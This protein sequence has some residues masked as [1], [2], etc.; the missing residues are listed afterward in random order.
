[1]KK[2]K[3]WTF[4]LLYY[5]YAT[6]FFI[7]LS[8]IFM[9]STGFFGIPLIS[10]FFADKNIDLIQILFAI[11]SLLVCIWGFMAYNQFDRITKLVKRTWS[12]C[13][14]LDPVVGEYDYKTFNPETRQWE[15]G[16][17]HYG[18][19]DFWDRDNEV[20]P[21]MDKGKYWKILIELQK[22]NK[23]VILQ[24]TKD[25]N[26]PFNQGKNNLAI[27]IKENNLLRP[28]NEI[29]KE[30]NKS[31]KF[32]II[33]PQWLVMNTDY[34]YFNAYFQLEISTFT[35]TIT[36]V[37][38]NIP[39]IIDELIEREKVIL[40]KPWNIFI[41]FITYL[42]KSLPIRLIYNRTKDMLPDA[43]QRRIQY[44]NDN[45]SRI[46]TNDLIG[47]IIIKAKMIGIGEK[48]LN[49]I[50]I[51]LKFLRNEY[52]KLGLGEG[53]SEYHN[54]HHSLE[55]AYMSLH[56]LPKEIHGLTINNKDYE[57]MLVAA[58]LHD[59]DP[60][61]D[62]KYRNSKYTRRPS[63]ISTIEQI[64]KKR[65]H[66]AYFSFNEEELIKFFR[67]NESPLL[68]TKEFSTIHPE[69][70]DNKK[71]P[72]ES[73]II[74]SLIWRTDYPY[75]EKSQSNFNQLLTEIKNN[76]FSGEKINLI[77]E[78]LS[79]ADLSVT[80]LSSDPLLAWNRVI[81]LYQELNLPIAEAVLR[82]D[83][84]LSFFSE[85][86]LF[87]EIISRKNFPQI[88]K[89]KWDNVYR[90]FH[91]GNPSNRINKIISDAR[92]KYNKINMELDMNNCDFIISNA[93]M[94][95][96]EFF[97]GIG[98]NKED[99]M[100]AQSKLKVIEIE[101]IEVFPGNTERL[102]PFIKDRSIDNFIITIYNDKKKDSNK[103]RLLRDLF[104]SYSSKLVINGTIQIIIGKDQDYEN[105]TSLLPN[106]EYKMVNISNNII[107]KD[108]LNDE[109]IDLEK[110]EK[111]KM[112]TILKKE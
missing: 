38:K 31:N 43:K 28:S 104:Y 1:M 80:Y 81:N 7:T 26:L 61:Q 60:M 41:S 82:T 30:S 66:D 13:N 44:T 68:P 65:I 55:V 98:K 86:S 33:I 112:I 111:V 74:E 14:K 77:A 89:Q 72:I 36:E 71:T 53:A 96:N 25:Q 108:I 73:K 97:I 46:S 50:S 83:R 85:E 6:G 64:K 5:K 78:I 69:Y 51:L 2:E 94:N 88:F 20:P 48:S 58:L 62:L 56:M 23:N 59:Y 93:I 79:L 29:K 16:F 102:L 100:M 10:N 105:I 95:K 35:N 12:L 75:D 67:K 3:K 11:Y 4:S 99:V 84:F 37:N 27:T 8:F 32:R 57:I 15:E 21:W 45:L 87:K 63:V 91:E 90:F 18:D 9:I 110:L 19:V 34:K 17:T 52:E 24:I 76:G 70:L 47:S 42:N 107:S 49:K 40:T 101:N 92:I 39:K 103:T 54:L 106:R 109:F 22:I